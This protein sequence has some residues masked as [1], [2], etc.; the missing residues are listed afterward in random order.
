MDTI[1]TKGVAANNG[2]TNLRRVNAPLEVQVQVVHAV[3]DAIAETIGCPLLHIKGPVVATQLGLE[4]RS[5]SDVDVLAP[6]SR[7]A[8]LIAALRGHGWQ[9][10]G[11]GRSGRATLHHAV[12]LLHPDW[13]CAIDLH[14]RFPGVE[15]APEEAFGW[16]WSSRSLVTVAGVEMYAPA[17]AEHALLLLLHA[18]RGRGS[19]AARLD[20]TLA[21]GS[22]SAAETDELIA[23]AEEL[24]ATAALAAVVPDLVRAGSDGRH[25]HWLLRARRSDGTTLWASR[26][27]ATEGLAARCAVLRAALFPGRPNWSWLHRWAKGLRDLPSALRAIRDARLELARHSPDA[28]PQGRHPV[29]RHDA[30]PDT[31]D[32]LP[33]AVAHVAGEAVM[34][35]AA[36][37]TGPL[38]QLDGTGWLIWE[39]ARDQRTVEE[40][41]EEVSRRVGLP[42]PELAHDVQS[43]VSLLAELGL[44]T[45]PPSRRV[46]R[47]VPMGSSPEVMNGRPVGPP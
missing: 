19:R 39:V 28:P 38:C 9:I 5:S 13:S 25:V 35:A 29:R 45:Q 42:A 2:S 43:F 6:P 46:D 30:G 20:V 27:L 26:L 7:R 1:P 40:T 15:R 4:R 24:R 37:P 10:V 23:A 18:A 14:D 44:L 34:W 12:V 11:E 36:L 3:V 47:D 22:L 17:R 33:R 31:R 41:V 16:L 21:H 32:D 8:E